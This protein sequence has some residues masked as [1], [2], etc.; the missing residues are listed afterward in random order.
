MKMLPRIGNDTF[1]RS[2]TMYA[3]LGLQG[4]IEDIGKA[5]LHELQTLYWSCDIP[6]FAG[7]L[8][9]FLFLISVLFRHFVEIICKTF[10]QRT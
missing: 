10:G 1:M 8:P 5:S 7:F 3:R 6:H 4:V 2:E 9:Y